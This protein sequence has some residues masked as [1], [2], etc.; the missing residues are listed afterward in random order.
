MFSLGHPVE[1]SMT[2]ERKLVRGGI[3][4]AGLVAMAVAVVA[5]TEQGGRSP[6]AWTVV[7]SALAVLASLASALGTH[8]VVEFQENAL[9]PALRVAFDFRRRYGLA[10]LSIANGGGS[11]AYDVRIKWDTPL[12]TVDGQ[13]VQVL[14]PR[15]R[16]PVLLARDEASVLLG[17]SHE[18]LKRYPNTAWSGS[19]SYQDASGDR[20]F[21]RFDLSAEHER[22]ALVHKEEGPKTEFELQKIPDRLESI[23]DELSKICGL[24]GGKK[25]EAARVTDAKQIEDVLRGWAEASRENS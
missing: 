19:I 2:F 21:K 3:Y 1:F 23:A 5:L 7:A 24:L 15:D 12:L 14:G 8:K 20:H 4:L 10:Q 11:H 9:A 25:A 16:L 17:A 18:F 13:E 22:L 6:A